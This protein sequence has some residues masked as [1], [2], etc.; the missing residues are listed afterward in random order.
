MGYPDFLYFD[1]NDDGIVYLSG[2]NNDPGRWYTEG[3]ADSTVLRST[4]DGQSWVELRDGL[5]VPVVGAFEAMT[6]HH[7]DGGMMLA[8]GTATGQIYTSED[9]AASWTCIA[10]DVAPVLQG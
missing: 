4:D 2:S 5:P 10:D 8:I 1:P 9:A 6:L 3:I 7:W